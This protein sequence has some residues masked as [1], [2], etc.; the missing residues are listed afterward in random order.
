MVGG[1][2]GVVGSVGVLGYWRLVKKNT[3]LR[4]T[5]KRC[6][7]TAGVFGKSSSEIL[8][9]DIR[10]FTVKQSFWERVWGVGTIGISSAAEDETEIVMHDVARPWKVHEAIDVYR[11]M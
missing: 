9:K 8:H 3:R 7:E 1:V 4:I 11:E 2:G 10:N 5:T 6:I